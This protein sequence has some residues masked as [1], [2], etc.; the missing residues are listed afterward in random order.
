MPDRAA[1]A[2]AWATDFFDAS[3]WTMRAPP[4]DSANVPTPV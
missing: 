3:T 4:A 1:L 2:R